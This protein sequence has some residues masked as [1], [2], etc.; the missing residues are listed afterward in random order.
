MRRIINIAFADWRRTAF[1]IFIAALLFRG[2]FI[3]TLQNG[4]YFPDSVDYSTAAVSLITNGEVGES[5][6]RPPGYA[7]FLA[8]IYMFFGESIFAVRIIESLIGAFLAVVIALIG[9][10]LG[11]EVGAFAG[12]LWSVY[13]LAVFIA[14]LVY[15]T[16]ITT[17]LLAGGVLC[18]LP[19]SR[20][21][22]A[23]RVFL[24]GVLWGLGTLTIPAVLA[25]AAVAALWLMYWNPGR[26]VAFV[27]VFFLGLA[28]TIVPWMIRDYRVY[29]R[30]VLIE[31]RVVEH[32]PRMRS[33][34][35]ELRQKKLEAI[36]Q[37]PGEY[38]FRT[39]NEFLHFWQLYPDRIQMSEPGYRKK[40]HEKKSRLVED[41]LFT[42]NSLIKVISILSTGPLFSFAILGAAAMW[43][44]RQR[45]RELALLWA[46][47]L[48]FAVVYSLF[49]AKTRYRIPIEPYIIILSAYG[50]KKTWDLVASR[51]A[52]GQVKAEV[53][54]AEQVRGSTFE[55]RG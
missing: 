48:S 13:P 36:A 1:V 20:E 50:I 21:L 54:A 52:C 37:H 35:K 6:D 47:I 53:E 31:P 33:A 24:A 27:S 4:F 55:V 38:V 9:R 2:V 43:F 12:L 17:L 32:L 15:P 19:E 23:K 39:A 28:L 16:Q 40:I 44:E 14:G 45:R 41:T 18:L 49:Y 11:A 34:D 29:G 3:S 30:V 26:R 46:T 10:R 7:A 51:F 25:T 8:G 42:T 5:Y 22:S